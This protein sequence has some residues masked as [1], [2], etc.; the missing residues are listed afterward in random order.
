M[1]EG[2]VMYNVGEEA[3]VYL[4]FWTLVKTEP[5]IRAMFVLCL[6]LV[7]SLVVVRILHWRVTRRYTRVKGLVGLADEEK[8]SKNLNAERPKLEESIQGH[9]QAIRR[10]KELQEVIRK[11]AG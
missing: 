3:P 1:A 8:Q 2:V 7:V 10:E 5:P 6:I 9:E 11:L 4:P